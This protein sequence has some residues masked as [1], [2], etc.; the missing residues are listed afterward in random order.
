MIISLKTFDERK[1][2]LEKS[3]N[4]DA[5]QMKNSIAWQMKDGVIFL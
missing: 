3:I 1:R 2:V 5:Q 4:D